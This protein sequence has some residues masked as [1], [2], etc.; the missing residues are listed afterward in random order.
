MA[1]GQR[2]DGLCPWPAGVLGLVPLVGRDG[3][4]EVLHRGFVV[5]QRPVEVARVPVD[6]DAAKVE[7]NRSDPRVHDPE[8]TGPGWAR[9][10][11]VAI[12]A[13][14]STESGISRAGV[15]QLAECQLPK[16]N[17]AGS[18]RGAGIPAHFLT[19]RSRDAIQNA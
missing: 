2:L 5:E 15:T 18:P 16:L 9:M 12:G 1:L 3:R 14:G 10:R 19:V 4:Q 13:A 17:V 11:V 8:A 6:E 7:G